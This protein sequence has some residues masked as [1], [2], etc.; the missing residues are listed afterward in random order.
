LRS[1]NR[2]GLLHFGQVGGG[3]FLGMD[4]QAGSGASIALTVTE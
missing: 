4:A 2:I 3:V 1:K